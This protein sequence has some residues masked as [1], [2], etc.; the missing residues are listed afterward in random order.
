LIRN[1]MAHKNKS[2]N[3]RRP[4]VPIMGNLRF[5]SGRG[6]TLLIL[7]VLAL[8]LALTLV[9]TLVLPTVSAAP[10]SAISLDIP[11]ANAVMTGTAFCVNAST[12]GD[13]ASNVTFYYRIG[14]SGGFT[15]FAENE[16]PSAGNTQ[17]GNCIDT[18]S[19]LGG[20]SGTYEINVTA[21][22]NSTSNNLVSVRNT[23]I[24]VD[25]V[26]PVVIFE[27]SKLSVHRQS[28]VGTNLNCQ[29]SSDA[30]DGSPTFLITVTKPS[31]ATVTSTSSSFDVRNGDI[32]ELGLYDATSK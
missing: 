19:V 3:N 9:L 6:V 11:A 12:T 17:F 20:D 28:S 16:T 31:R 15:Q 27:S 23:G 25:N 8:P 5:K 4:T 14:S 18:T 32:D 30:L 13:T 7:A 1:K 26:A 29:K 24:Y 22:E 2:L 21:F 10:L